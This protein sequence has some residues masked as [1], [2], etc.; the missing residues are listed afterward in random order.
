L[1]WITGGNYEIEDEQFNLPSMTE[2]SAL[3]V[4]GRHYVKQQWKILNIDL[5]KYIIDLT[6][7]VV[8]YVNNGEGN[9]LYVGQ[10]PNKQWKR[11]ISRR[12]IHVK[13]HHSHLIPLH[14]TLEMNNLF[15]PTYTPIEEAIVSILAGL[16][17]SVAINKDY[18][19]GLHNMEYGTTSVYLYHHA[20]LVGV[21]EYEKEVPKALLPECCAYLL[22]DIEQFIKCE[23]L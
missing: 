18:A 6:L 15:F 7:P 1:F 4:A 22:E 2:N 13:N 12:I 19:V 11:A 14:D 23:V 9:A 20:V 8:G 17:D 5:S 10:E 3:L 16:Y 21:I